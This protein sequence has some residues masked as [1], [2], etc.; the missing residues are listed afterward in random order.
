MLNKLLADYCR[1][2]YLSGHSEP[3]QIGVYR[4]S[5]LSWSCIRKQWNYYKFLS[6]KKAEEIPDDI[7][8]LLAGGVVFHRLIQGLKDEQGRPYWD[9][10]EI[11]CSIEV[12]VAGGE[13]IK[14]IGHA[15]AI[16]GKG[17]DKIVYEFKHV[18]QLPNKPQFPHLLQLNFYLGALGVNRGSLLYVG[19]LP[20]GGLAVKEFGWLYSNWHMEHLIARAQMLHTL[21]IHNEAP[22]CSCKN[23]VHELGQLI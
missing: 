9:K 13:K 14:I 2:V 16:R 3:V 8:L 20:H 15:D 1:K 4:P 5:V 10:T 23:R 12:N 22:R 6:G 7:I 11:E 19:Y 21:L 17:M 18:R